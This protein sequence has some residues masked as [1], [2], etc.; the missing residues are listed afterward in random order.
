MDQTKFEAIRNAPSQASMGNDAYKPGANGIAP[1]SDR[2]ASIART[3]ESDSIHI[4]DFDSDTIRDSLNEKSPTKSFPNNGSSSAAV[5]PSKPVLRLKAPIVHMSSICSISES[6]SQLS[7]PARKCSVATPSIDAVTIFCPKC[8]FILQSVKMDSV[9]SYMETNSSINCKNCFGVVKMNET[10]IKTPAS[11]SICS[12]SE[13]AE[14]FNQKASTPQPQSQA[15]KA[16]VAPKDDTHFDFS[17]E[18]TSATTPSM[19]TTKAFGNVENR[20]TIKRTSVT[21]QAQSTKSK[22]VKINASIKDATFFDVAVV[23]CLLCPKWNS[24]GYLWSLEYLS[25]RVVEITDLI[26]R[27]QDNFFQV[28]SSSLPSSL[29]DLCVLMGVGSF[30]IEDEEFDLNMNDLGGGF[31]SSPNKMKSGAGGVANE[32]IELINQIYLETDF[33]NTKLSFSNMYYYMK[34]KKYEANFQTRIR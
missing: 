28:R 9:S 19:I 3:D 6:P 26:L 31:R 8:N 13:F 34:R 33:S 17:F 18:G 1:V 29:N 4:S 27:E 23:R 32:F 25:Y 14:K 24:E 2:L 11:A 21:T 5:L 22:L 20:K 7:T 16:F 15:L 30:D 12:M 10:A